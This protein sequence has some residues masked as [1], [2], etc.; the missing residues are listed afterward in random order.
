MNRFL[1]LLITSFLAVNFAHAKAETFIIDGSHSSIQFS[2]RHFVAKTN[3]NFGNFEGIIKVN[4]DDFTDNYCEASIS[5]D[6]IDT[7]S[8]KRDAHLQEA[9][10]FNSAQTPL[11]QF[12]STQWEITDKENF[13]KV[14]GDLSMNNVTKSV[15]LDVEL[16]GFGAGMRGAYLSGWEGSTSINRT[17]WNINGGK[18]AV[19]EIVDI[20]INIEAVRQ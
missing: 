13:F 18:G 4:Q 9:D 16:F 15:T 8:P 17:E 14:T 1:G 5:I 12:K 20:K 6:S 11:I 19:G 3:G 2:I 10:Y 7:D